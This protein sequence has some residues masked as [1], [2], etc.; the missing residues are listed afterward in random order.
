MLFKSINYKNHYQSLQTEN[1]FNDSYEEY[2]RQ[3]TED[4]QNIFKVLNDED[5]PEFIVR[6]FKEYDALGNI[7]IVPFNIPL[8]AGVTLSNSTMHLVQN[9]EGDYALL[10][11]EEHAKVL[12]DEQTE[13]MFNHELTHYR[14][15]VEHRFE[16]IDNH[17]YWEGNP[18][19]WTYYLE[20][21]AR[22]KP[23]YPQNVAMQIK[24]LPWEREAYVFNAH[25][26]TA[27]DISAIDED[28][29]LALL[30]LVS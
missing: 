14:Q 20:E 1:L 25:A 27:E 11:N 8:W 26:M 28:L 9:D 12:N 7:K 21:V 22:L 18:D 30:E 23:T 24:M 15:F 16:V 5:M 6:L 4:E 13:V 2:I 17:H 3:V 29:A 19:Y 10:V